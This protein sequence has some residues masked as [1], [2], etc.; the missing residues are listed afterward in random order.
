MATIDLRY[1]RALA[2]VVANQQMDIVAAQGDLNRFADVLAESAELREVLDNPAIPEPQKMGVLNTLGDRLGLSKPVR[3]FLAVVSRHGRILQLRE[4]A[5]TF[6]SLADEETQV[7]EVVIS[8]AHPLDDGARRLLEAQ[9]TRLAGGS[10]IKT[11]YEED[12]S[13]LGGA[14]VK[15][16][17]TVYDG[18]VKMQLAQLKERMATAGLR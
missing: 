9:A 6:A 5:N 15:I 10:R 18:S 2:E 7:A 13:L 3:N 14:V 16:G 17:S 4:M 1:A 8:S 12:P 11:T